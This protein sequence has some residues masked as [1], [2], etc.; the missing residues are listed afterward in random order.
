[1]SDQSFEGKLVDDFDDIGTDLANA[2]LVED[3]SFVRGVA[4]ALLEQGKDIAQWECP[5]YGIH[6]RTGYNATKK[7]QREAL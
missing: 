3:A 2:N 5:D 7:W 6:Y 1:M 4:D